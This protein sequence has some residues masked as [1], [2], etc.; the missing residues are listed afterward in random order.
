MKGY[1]ITFYKTYDQSAS[2]EGWSKFSYKSGDE[3]EFTPPEDLPEGVYQWRAAIRDRNF[4]SENSEV[5]SFT[6]G[7]PDTI[8]VKASPS[9]LPPGGESTS[10]ITATVTSAGGDPV[11]DEEVVMHLD[12]DG[13]LSEV[14]NN[15]DGTYTATYTTEVT[16]GTVKITATATKSHVSDTVELMLAFGPYT[17]VDIY[18][19]KEVY[20]PDDE[21]QVYADFSNY[22]D[23][24]IMGIATSNF[25]GLNS[26]LDYPKSRFWK[27]DLQCHTEKINRQVTH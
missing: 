17:K 8:E 9:I 25:V 18:T 4:R 12:G 21:M 20:Q 19:D 11:T 27:I 22:T 7:T 16:E 5:R 14:T 2:L 1:I 3:A 10:E 26:Y 6:L 24:L 15:G 23:K 13:S